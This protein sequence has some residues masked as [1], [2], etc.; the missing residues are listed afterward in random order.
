MTSKLLKTIVG[1]GIALGAA[2]ACLG[3][4]STGELEPPR[5][6]G[7]PTSEPVPTGS[8]R[9]DASPPDA[10]PDVVSTPPDADVSDAETGDA[11]VTDAGSLDASTDAGDPFCDVSW[12]PTKGGSPGKVACVDP[13]GDCADTWPPWRCYRVVGENT[14]SNQF[15]FEGPLYCIDG[16]WRCP[17]GSSEGAS[18]LCWGPLSAGQ[19]CSDA[20][21]IVDG[22]GADGGG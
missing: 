1:V 14:C 9:P 20:G 7:E 19:S 6:D 11:S 3:R 18:C 13:L 17:P 2:P 16:Q 21:V 8:S 5:E 12:P 4:S 10:G 15:Q 22:G